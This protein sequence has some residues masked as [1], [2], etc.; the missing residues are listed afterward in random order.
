LSEEKEMPE[1]RAEDMKEPIPIPTKPLV[2]AI[3]TDDEE[4]L[5]LRED[6]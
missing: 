5:E 1:A 3:P 4:F 2:P 6:L